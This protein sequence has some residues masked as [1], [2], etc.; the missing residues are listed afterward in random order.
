MPVN[1]IQIQKY[2]LVH[3]HH[4]LPRLLP[5]IQEGEGDVGGEGV[6]ER[7]AELPAV[8]HLRVVLVG[9]RVPVAVEAEEGQEGD[10]GVGVAEQEGAEGAGGGV[11]AGIF[12]T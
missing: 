2:Y 6:D 11:P 4:P 12:Q 1:F 8:P 10:E 3:C 9:E 7:G 5:A